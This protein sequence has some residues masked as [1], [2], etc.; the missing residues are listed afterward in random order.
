MTFILKKRKKERKPLSPPLLL[1]YFFS[2]LTSLPDLSLSLSISLSLY[3]SFSLSNFPL[4]SQSLL[5][6]SSFFCDCF[7][8]ENSVMERREREERHAD[9]PLLLLLSSCTWALMGKEESLFFPSLFL[10]F[11]FSL[12]PLS[13]LFCALS[14]TPSLSLPL[15]LSPDHNLLL[16]FSSYQNF[17]SFLTLSCFLMQDA[18]VKTLAPD[19]WTWGWL[20]VAYQT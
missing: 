12:P 5:Q 8:M 4:S 9:S 11:S 13:S 20:R 17:T 15:S 16:S 10:L 14:L 6:Y 3:L 19:Q 7:A 18:V 1:L 2:P